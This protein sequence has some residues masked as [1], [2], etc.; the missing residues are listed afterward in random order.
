MKEGGAD[1]IMIHSKVS[2]LGIGFPCVSFWVKRKLKE[3][4]FVYIQRMQAKRDEVVCM[5]RKSEMVS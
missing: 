5:G 2:G 3:R 4:E 1:G